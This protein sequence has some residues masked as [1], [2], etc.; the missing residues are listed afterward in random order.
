MGETGE[1]EEAEERAG[2]RLR[3]GARDGVKVCFT[4]T[5]PML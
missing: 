3:G 2:R 5:Q 1:R 4:E